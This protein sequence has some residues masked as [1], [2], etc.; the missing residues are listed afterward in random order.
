MVEHIPL[1]KVV[2]HASTTGARRPSAT[3]IP[4]PEN[5]NGEKQRFHRGMRKRGGSGSAAQNTTEEGDGVLTTMGR[6]Y[7]AVLNFSVVTRYFIYVLPLALVL[8]VPIIVG[9]TVAP[10]A[11]IGGIRIVWLFI[12]IEIG[13]SL[14]LDL[15]RNFLSISA[16]KLTISSL[17]ELMGIQDRCPLPPTRLPICRRCRQ[18]WRPQI[19]LGPTV[20]GDSSL[21][22][23]LGTCIAINLH[24]SE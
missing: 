17:V 11:M 5:E 16:R 20:A 3:P 4:V 6:F 2:S 7:N 13:K 9:A 19:C 18:P 24:S 10:K 8:A 14:R 1:E 12:W 15:A 23:W 22:R 21:P